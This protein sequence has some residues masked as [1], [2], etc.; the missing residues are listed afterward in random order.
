MCKTSWCSSEIQELKS[1]ISIVK[2]EIIMKNIILS[3]LIILMAFVV[4]VGNPL[5]E[6]P[7]VSEP[8][9]YKVQK[10]DTLWDIAEKNVSPKFDKRE[11]IYEM[12]IDPLLKPGD[13]ITIVSWK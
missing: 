8:F 5:A 9:T 1:V 2:G 4:L 13:T 3:S 12:D 10:G 11:W 6:K 7:N